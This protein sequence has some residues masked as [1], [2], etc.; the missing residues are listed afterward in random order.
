MVSS[1]SRRDA[2]ASRRGAPVVRP[3]RENI[4]QKR[5]LLGVKNENESKSSH[6]SIEGLKLGNASRCAFV[7]P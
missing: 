6:A 1:V 3:V 5:V 2:V 4:S 7:H